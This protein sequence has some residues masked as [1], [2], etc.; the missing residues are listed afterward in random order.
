MASRSTFKKA[1]NSLSCAV[2]I[3]ESDKTDDILPT[4]GIFSSKFFTSS[5]SAFENANNSLS[6]DVFF[7]GFDKTDQASPTSLKADSDKE[8]LLLSG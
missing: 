7:T 8:N 6:Y 2:F 3:S 1:N 5:R 4:T